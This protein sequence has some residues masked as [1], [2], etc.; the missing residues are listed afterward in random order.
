[1]LRF[2]FSGAQV[3]LGYLWS[4]IVPSNTDS[5]FAG[6]MLLE[7]CVQR[8][9][10]AHRE[11]LSHRPPWISPAHLCLFL[12]GLLKPQENGFCP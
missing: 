8:A 3:D 2:C 12:C 11:K 7:Q 10:P 6:M 5:S 1:M 4:E 9:L